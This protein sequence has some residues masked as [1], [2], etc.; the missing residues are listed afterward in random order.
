[1]TSAADKERKPCDSWK[2]S[3]N[4][5]GGKPYGRSRLL[6]VN[7]PAP[8]VSEWI[9]KGPRSQLMHGNNSK[10]KAEEQ[11]KDISELIVLKQRL[12]SHIQK[13]SREQVNLQTQDI[14]YGPSMALMPE[15]EIRRPVV[16]AWGWKVEPTV[17][18]YTSVS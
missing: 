2:R 8:N 13:F 14:L 15:R 16:C 4:L 12:L 7:L 17:S 10:R 6:A 1:M 3:N 11:V 18:F 5:K 9:G